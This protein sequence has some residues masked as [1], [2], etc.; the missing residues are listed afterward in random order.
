M[1]N[2]I[3]HSPKQSKIRGKTCILKLRQFCINTER[4]SSNYGLILPDLLE[5]LLKLKDNF[6]CTQRGLFI[7][8]ILSFTSVS[9]FWITKNIKAEQTRSKSNHTVACWRVVAPVGNVLSTSACS[10]VSIV[11]WLGVQRITCSWKKNCLCVENKN[12]KTKQTRSALFEST[13]SLK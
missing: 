13:Q 11:A 3:V 8:T 10:V 7:V 6:A 12:L 4:D 2:F 9:N 5:I 1:L